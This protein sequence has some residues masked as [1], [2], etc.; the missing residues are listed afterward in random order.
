[1]KFAIVLVTVLMLAP[2]AH[3][4][5]VGRYCDDS[6]C[7][8]CNR[9]HLIAGHGQ[10]QSV[11]AV[12]YHSQ[13]ISLHNLSHTPQT[14][15]VDSTPQSI[16]DAMLESVSPNENE[17]LCDIGCGDGR[18]VIAAAKKYGCR[19][20]GIEIKKDVA[21]LAKVNVQKAGLGHL[22]TIV[23]GDARDYRF[24]RVDIITMYL[25]PDLMEELQPEMFNATK[26]VSH[27]HKIPNVHNRKVVVQGNHSVYVWS[28]LGSVLRF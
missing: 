21:D 26:I 25:F 17:I 3:A 10:K 1:M 12:L 8:M 28:R 2:V 23:H 6:Y 19:A 11:V 15:H 9:L 22:I 24:E 7:D 27:N 16:V 4:H 20:I 5:D 18:I 13:L 14:L